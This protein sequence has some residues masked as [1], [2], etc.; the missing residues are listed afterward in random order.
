[1]LFALPC[2]RAEAVEF[3]AVAENEALREARALMA[4]SLFEEAIAKLAAAEPQARGIARQQAEIAALRASALL[5]LPQAPER[6]PAAREQLVRLFHLDAQGA[7]LSSASAAAQRLA[8]EVRASQP[9]VLHERLAAARSGR[10][11]HMR[12]TLVNGPPGARMVLRYRAEPEG[13]FGDAESGLAS[14]V[15]PEDYVTLALESNAPGAFEAWLK[16]GEA[17]VPAG[18]ERVLRYYF[19]AFDAAGQL[20]D[21]NGSADEPARMLLSELHA[22]EALAG[23]AV[24]APLDEVAIGNRPP[25]APPSPPFY[26]RWAF[27]LPVGGAL[28]VGAGVVVYALLPKPQPPQGSLGNV[29]IR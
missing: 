3:R 29:V 6:I 13:D 25:P 12:A 27:W 21:R 22:E 19:E 26:K 28:A 8:Q 7:S 15:A 18:G 1:L 20:V 2:P 11:L 4:Q 17:G 9:L 24:L 16:P 10:L 14:L 23:T 5:G